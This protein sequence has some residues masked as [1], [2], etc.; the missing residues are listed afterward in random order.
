MYKNILKHLK[1]HNNVAD[2]ERSFITMLMIENKLPDEPSAMP[3]YVKISTRRKGVF[4]ILLYLAIHSSVISAPS[5][6]H[7]RGKMTFWTFERTAIF[8]SWL[9]GKLIWILL[10]AWKE[11][12]DIGSMFKKVV[13]F[14]TS[15]SSPS[16]A[17][18]RYSAPDRK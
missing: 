17:L 18:E 3:R 5:S 2:E 14:S 6:D 12:P 16:I 13:C 9:T 8:F 1:H 10:C 7:K 11:T 4:T 15:G